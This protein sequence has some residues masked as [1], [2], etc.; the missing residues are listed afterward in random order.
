[1]KYFTFVRYLD[2][3][4]GVTLHDGSDT[5]RSQAQAVVQSFLTN[6]YPK[7]HINLEQQ[8][9]GKYLECTV[10]E[11]AG[12]IMFS[13]WNKNLPHTFHMYVQ[14]AK[15]FETPT[16]QQLQPFE[17]K[18]WH[19]DRRVHQN[20][21]QQFKCTIHANRFVGE[22]LRVQVLRIFQSHDTPGLQLH[23]EETHMHCGKLGF[24]QNM[25]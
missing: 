12:D 6:C 24:S 10:H 13:H 7:P 21:A 15:D 2:D 25:H 9:D 20:H 22:G 17:T 23:G 18:I 16:S 19:N 14:H 11:I 3:I 4:L 1:M 5:D 8:L